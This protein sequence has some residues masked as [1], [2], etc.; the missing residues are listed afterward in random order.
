MIKIKKNGEVT[1]TG[2]IGDVLAEFSMAALSVVDTLVKSSDI[3]YE[4]AALIT[5]KACEAG[6]EVAKSKIEEDEKDAEVAEKITDPVAEEHFERAMNDET[7]PE[8]VKEMMTKARESGAE[9]KVVFV[10]TDKAEESDFERLTNG[11][12]IIEKEN[13]AAKEKEDLEDEHID[14]NWKNN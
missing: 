7:V 10:N 4:K 2:N 14:P 11:A 1:L 6:V 13:M 5:K 3:S 8:F 9:V 12:E